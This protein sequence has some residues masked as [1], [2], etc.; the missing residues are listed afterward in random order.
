MNKSSHPSN[1]CCPVCNHN[2]MPQKAWLWGC[3]RCGFISS[4]L[5]AG[6]GTGVEGLLTLRR[7]N[8]E[9]LLDRVGRI[10]P[11][12]GLT[13][14]EVG[15]STG[16]F[17]EAS[18]RRRAKVIGVEPEREKARVA[19][20]KGFEV[21]DGFFPECLPAEQ[22]FD[23]IAFND[24]FEHLPQPSAALRVCELRLN[25]GGLLILNLPDSD[26]ILYSAAEILERLGIDAALERL[27]QKNF[28]SPHVSYF[29]RYNLKKLVAAQTGL[30]LVHESCLRTMTAKG[31]K[32]RIA[33]SVREPL[34][35][36]VRMGLL[37]LVPLQRILPSDILLQVYKKR[38]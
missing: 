13:L 1:T 4:T 14:L 6:A 37:A 18:S 12:G 36:L 28:A 35:S 26:G 29:N 7:M 25:P 22:N 30:D 9:T 8:F 17:L 21:I 2:M 38:T 20:S 16:L 31:L 27:W 19:R 3:Q 33:T 32:D 23:I 15:C 34:A 5:S 24:V 11:L 10:T